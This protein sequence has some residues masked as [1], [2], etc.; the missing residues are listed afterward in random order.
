MVHITSDLIIK[1][2]LLLGKFFVFLLECLYLLIFILVLLLEFLQGF[3]HLILHLD[4][5]ISLAQLLIQ[6]LDL[7]FL[8]VTDW[9]M[10]QS[11]TV[12][13]LDFAL[14]VWADEPQLFDHVLVVPGQLLFEPF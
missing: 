7:V 2:F 5:L 6:P 1:I 14:L 10:L 4:P 11:I 8:V 12:F 13:Q 3:D 9:D